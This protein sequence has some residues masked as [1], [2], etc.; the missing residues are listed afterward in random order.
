MRFKLYSKITLKNTTQ[1]AAEN[2]KSIYLLL[3]IRIAKQKLFDIWEIFKNH[4]VK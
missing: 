4:L 1:T 2:T 3:L